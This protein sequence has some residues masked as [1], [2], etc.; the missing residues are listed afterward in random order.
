M[1]WENLI[2]AP[3]G[4]ILYP[5]R[6]PA[7]LISCC[8][9]LYGEKHVGITGSRIEWVKS[10]C[11]GLLSMTITS[12]ADT[13]MFPTPLFCIQETLSFLHSLQSSYLRALS[14]YPP[15]EGCSPQPWGRALFHLRLKCCQG[16]QQ[17]QVF[18]VCF[19]T[20]EKWKEAPVLHLVLTNCHTLWFYCS[21]VC[22]FVLF[23]KYIYFPFDVL[24]NT[25]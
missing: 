21:L 3:P 12:Q 2:S 10:G 18:H 8:A 13:K 22:C 9:W 7:S 1:F 17:Q 23:L 5:G 11:S 19:D 16:K 14:A 4:I 25:S 24:R 15:G 20:G 6:L